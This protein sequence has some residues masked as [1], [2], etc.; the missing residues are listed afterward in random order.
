MNFELWSPRPSAICTGRRV[1]NLNAP[2]PIIE[3]ERTSAFILLR[4]F[5]FGERSNDDG[6]W[7]T[8]I[9]HARGLVLRPG[10]TR[11]RVW[12]AMYMRLFNSLFYY[13]VF[14]FNSTLHRV[15]EKKIRNS[16]L[17]CY[18]KVLA[19]KPCEKKMPKSLFLFSTNE[20][21]KG[22][23]EMGE[24]ADNCRTTVVSKETKKKPA[25]R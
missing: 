16:K 23:K 1:P 25:E 24:T 13:F 22:S 12:F 20:R 9:N 7:M 6:W 19:K 4:K 5:D 15:K 21:T 17:P 18:R 3:P 8:M 2:I 10:H 11:P 14:V